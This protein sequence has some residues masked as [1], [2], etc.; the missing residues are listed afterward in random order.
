MTTEE[1]LTRLAESSA[2]AIASVLEL[3][4]PGAVETGGVQIHTRGADPLSTLSGP[5]IVASVSYVDGVTGGNLFA[6]TARGAHRMAAAMMGTEPDLDAEIGELEM[7]AV[8]E[9]ANQMLAAAAAAT[10]GVLGQAIQISPPE[11]RLL[12]EAALEDDG[13]GAHVVSASFTFAGEPCRLVQLVPSAFTVRMTRALDELSAEVPGPAASAGG[14]PD[15]GSPAGEADASLA[16]ALREVTVRLSAELGRTRMPIGR[17]VDLP[18]GHVV[19]LDRDVEEPIDLYVNGRQF[20]LG[21]LLVDDA[22]AWT[23]RI[24]Q[25]TLDPIP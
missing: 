18:T 8:G 22:G 21:R 20:A 12:S 4:A 17:L 14:T 9:A 25:I 1:A 3:F 7:S 23:V 6:I 19:E 10:S 16:D 11:T 2:E 13:A 15:A 5:V 24:D